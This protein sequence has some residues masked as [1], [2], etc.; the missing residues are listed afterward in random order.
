MG[1]ESASS[2]WEAALDNLRG[3]FDATGKTLAGARKGEGDAAK[4]VQRAEENLAEGSCGHE[5]D[6]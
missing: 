1:V 4:A 2:G 6:R 3:A 5:A